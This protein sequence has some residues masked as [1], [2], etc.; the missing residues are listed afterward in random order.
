MGMLME[1]Y[2]IHYRKHWYKGPPE[3]SASSI[4]P[5]FGGMSLISVH[6]RKCNVFYIEKAIEIKKHKNE[7]S[8]QKLFII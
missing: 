7:Y 5:S 1:L 4:T 8:V 6:S 3:K 2:L